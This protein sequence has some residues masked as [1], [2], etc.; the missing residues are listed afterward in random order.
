MEISQQIANANKWIEESSILINGSSITTTATTTTLKPRV[1][2]SLLHL[3]LEHCR[4]I[5]S[6]IRYEVF[7][8]ALALLRPQVEAYIRDVWFDRC[9]Q[10]E[11]ANIKGVRLF[12]G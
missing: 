1:S 10:E 4:G 7:G 11:D 2:L 9:A 12:L 8:S 5:T 3:S 6:L